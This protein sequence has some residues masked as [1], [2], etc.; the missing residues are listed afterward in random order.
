MNQDKLNI[1]DDRGVL[2]S[3][4][5]RYRIPEHYGKGELRQVI[6][7]RDNEG[8]TVGCVAYSL[9][10]MENPDVMAL[11]ITVAKRH[12][13]E[14]QVS[15]SVAH[16]LVQERM[17]QFIASVVGKQLDTKS[18]HSALRLVSIPRD[19]CCEPIPGSVNLM[20]I[21]PKHVLLRSVVNSVAVDGAWQII[22]RKESNLG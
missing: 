4:H 2:H 15:R 16:A 18:W 5:E 14:K 7:L 20:K 12:P 17:K 19:D 6:H 22:H 8:N 9:L 13:R 21:K 3:F 1:S 10:S 11:A